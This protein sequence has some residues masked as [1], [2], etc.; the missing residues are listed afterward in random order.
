MLKRFVKRLLS[1]LLL[2]ALFVLVVIGGTLGVQGWRLYRATAAQKPIAGLYDEISSRPGFASCDQLPQTYID[3]VISVEDSRFEKHHGIDP[4]AIVR[5]LW[6]DLRTRSLAEG[7]ST[8]TQ[9]LAKN[10]LFTQEKQMARKAAEMFAAR[11]IEDYY[12]KQQIFE[13]YAGSCYFGNQWSGVAQAAQGYFGKPTRELTRAECV[14]LAGLP[15]APSVYA[16]N[17]ELARRRALVVV[18]RMERAK[19]LTHTQALELRDEV[20]ALPLVLGTLFQQLYSFADTVIVGRCLGT[21]ALG[22][23]G[24]TYSLN[25]LI[26]GF[27]LGSCTGFGIPVAQSFG[28]RDSEDM[29]KYLFNGAVLCVVLSVVFTIV[30][31]LTAAPLLQLIHTPAELFPDAVA[32]IRIIFLGIPAT[33]LFNYTSTVLHS[34]GDSQHPFYFLLISSFLNIGLDWLFIVPL[35]MGVEGAA[36]ATVVSQLFSGLLCT[37][38]FFTRVEGIHFTRENCVLSAGHC[39]RLA[40]IGLPMGFEYSVSAIGAFI[41]QDAI[42]LLGS[43]AVAAQTAGEKI[44]Q[45][46]TVPMASVGTAMATY[47]GQ[48]HGAHRTDRVRQG[49]RDGCILQLCYCAAAWVVLFFVKG[50]AVGLVLGDADPAVTSGAV[51]YLTVISVLFCIN[52]LLMVFRNTLQGLGYSVQAVISGVGELIGRA[53]CGWLAVHSLGYFGICIANP[54]AWGLALLYCVFMVTRVLKKENA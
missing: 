46:F 18:E 45:M 47:V 54:I 14:V 17:G 52:G 4:A 48:N 29:H 24:T 21:D 2:A 11:D 5:A 26:L 42:N 1:C 38:W 53:L 15:N 3:A 32:Y 20:S 33:V 9:Q 43:T 8:L 41:M 22:A 30:T 19:K 12:S 35:G 16:A 28:A 7:G 44:R 6:A 40:Y 10:E 50:W 51:E 25:F 27:V 23:V 37:W 13:M 34:L 36:I 49:I 31:T 39:G